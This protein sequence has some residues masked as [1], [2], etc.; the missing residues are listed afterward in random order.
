[1]TLTVNPPA[2]APAFQETRALLALHSHNR[3]PRP[4]RTSALRSTPSPAANPSKS[5]KP[6]ARPVRAP[7][8]TLPSWLDP[9]AQDLLKLTPMCGIVGYVGG[10]NALDVVIAGLKRLEYRG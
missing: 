9:S 8:R 5:R 4:A 2:I 3:P 1:Q 10:Q 7:S 6:S